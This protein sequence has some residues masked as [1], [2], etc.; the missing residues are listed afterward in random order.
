MHLFS[1]SKRIA[2]FLL[3][4]TT[5]VATGGAGGQEKKYRFREVATVGDVSD[6]E[7]STNVVVELRVAAGGPDLPPFEYFHRNRRKYRSTIL[8]V[9]KEQRPTA[10]RR[11]YSIAR[12]VEA[13][14]GGVPNQKVLSLQGKTLTLRLDAAGK[15][16]LRIAK[17]KISERERLDI[18]DDLQQAKKPFFPERDLTVGEEWT[19]DVD[20]FVEGLEGVN[21]GVLK[22]KFAEVTTYRGHPCARIQVSLTFSGK[23]PGQSLTLEV[24][25]NGDLFHAIDLQRVLAVSLNGPVIMRGQEVIQG[26]TVFFTGEGTMESEFS[27]RWSKVG[28]KTVGKK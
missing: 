16:V 8:S 10:V 28:G 25:Q 13:Q 19:Q 1:C 14:I 6:V 15:P 2:L 17:G 3:V 12:T 23:V 27:E 5:L 18:S 24:T 22:A 26:R 9:D 4:T 21:R 20:S 7:N 11:T